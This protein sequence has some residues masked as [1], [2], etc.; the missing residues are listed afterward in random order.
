MIHVNRGSEPK[1]FFDSDVV[2][3]EKKKINEFYNKDLIV[4]SQQ[5]YDF[6]NV[7]RLLRHHN[8]MNS[9]V[10]T[11]NHKCAYCERRISNPQVEHFRPKSGAVNTSLKKEFSPLHYGWLA[12]E[13]SNLYCAC[14]EC[15]VSKR[16]YFPVMQQRAGLGNKEEILKEEKLLLD[17]CVDYPEEHLYFNADGSVSSLSYI[18]EIT[19]KILD[20][21]SMM[22]IE[23]RYHCIENLKL[24]LNLLCDL[25]EHK[26]VE[27]L[28]VLKDS[29]LSEFN[30]E[31]EY[32]AWKY[33]YFKEFVLSK[34]DILRFLEK[35]KKWKI[36]IE[37]A[38]RYSDKSYL[39]HDG[40]VKE[41]SY[42]KRPWI[43]RIEVH[44]LRGIHNFEIAFDIEN[45]EEANWLMLLG[46]NGTGKSTLLQAM[47][48][49]FM[50]AN[51]RRKININAKD[52][53]SIGKQQG[54]VNIYLTGKEKC[55]TLNFSVHS[56]TFK[57]Y[58]PDEGEDEMILLGYGST[59]LF[60]MKKNKYK[61]EKNLERLFDPFIPLV[62]VKDWLCSLDDIEFD[63]VAVTIKALLP[64]S[65]DTLLKRD[66]NKKEVYIEE[67]K[68]VS[69]NDLSHG[70]K[71]VIAL[72]CDIMKGLQDD[73]SS[74]HIAEGIVLI[75]EIDAH[76]HPKW[77]MLI[78]KNLREH[79]PR[80][81]FIVTSHDP[82]CLKGICENEIAILV[83]NPNSLITT[84]QTEGL[85]SPKGMRVDQI[86]TS[87]FFGLG[88]TIDPEIEKEVNRYYELLAIKERTEEEEE[89]LKNLKER[90]DKKYSYMGNSPRERMMYEIID[91]YLAQKNCS[92]IE[93]LKLSLYENTKQK[94]RQIWGSVEQEGDYS[95]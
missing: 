35:D 9:F 2:K 91:E 33:Q 21:N 14:Q 39:K 27:Q 74:S 90:L 44:N 92:S 77:K 30:D 69:L 3:N 36:I 65:A 16:N 41:N 95:K 56:K 26:H 15:N 78:V 85:P 24:K 53:V 52:F 12:L 6:N 8:F 71:S 37:V 31:S 46:E 55:Y 72:T 50:D 59:R 18:G 67:G 34:P 7:R 4:L 66:I 63:Q 75:D 11:F 60:P 89:D 93:G 51:A 68:R 13:W 28:I 25:I 61:K 49:V 58:K 82:L 73:V 22:L 47:A 5:K 19:I 62:D 23:M 43:R 86:L 1:E 87:E 81:Q 42:V 20:L 80:I 88:S 83:K 48:L 57:V 64:I 70:Y 32:L 40:D 94:I 17:P 10:N 54:Y 45:K 79:F 38:N 76:L 84:V 29:I